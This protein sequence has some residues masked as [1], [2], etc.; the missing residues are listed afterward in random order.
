MFY[1]GT[2]FIAIA[3][4]LMLK[5]EQSVKSKRHRLGTQH[6]LAYIAQLPLDLAWGLRENAE[7]V[8]WRD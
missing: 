1:L 4:L 5:H 7:R 3:V 2:L 6:L 8:R